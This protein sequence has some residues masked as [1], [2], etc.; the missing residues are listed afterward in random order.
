MWPDPTDVSKRKP[1]Y[2]LGTPANKISLYFCI[3][4]IGIAYGFINLTP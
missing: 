3:G 1:R 2:L 4:V